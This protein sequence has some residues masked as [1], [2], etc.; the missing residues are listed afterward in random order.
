MTPKPRRFPAS[1]FLLS[2]TPHFISSKEAEGGG[3]S[4]ERNLGSLVLPLICSMSLDNN[5]KK[6]TFIEDIGQHYLL[7]TP[8]DLLRV[9]TNNSLFHVTTK[10]TEAPSG[11]RPRLWSSSCWLPGG[12]LRSLSLATHPLHLTT[13]RHSC[14][15]TLCLGLS[16]LFCGTRS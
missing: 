2:F 13:A 7:S 16:F 9:G 15:S 5:N 11:Y 14:L 10:E 12:E 6:L 4:P 1:P 3:L 8:E